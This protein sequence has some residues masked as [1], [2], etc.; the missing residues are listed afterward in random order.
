MDN[1]TWSCTTNDEATTAIAVSHQ[2]PPLARARKHESRLKWWWKRLWC[3]HF[4]TEF[5]TWTVD[6]EQTDTVEKTI[7]AVEAC[8]YCWAT[9][10]VVLKPKEDE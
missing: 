6:T 10:E 1:A 3:R 2:R 8:L 4:W 5:F 7:Y 9:R